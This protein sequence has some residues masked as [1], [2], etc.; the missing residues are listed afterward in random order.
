[1]KSGVYNF[2]KLKHT[3][4]KCLLSVLLFFFNNTDQVETK[5]LTFQFWEK[6]NVIIVPFL[7]TGLKCER[8]LKL[9]HAQISR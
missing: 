8:K 7:L 5:Y 6:I 3:N 4:L 1:M 9:A 2:A